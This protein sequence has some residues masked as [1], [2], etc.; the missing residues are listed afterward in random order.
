MKRTTLLIATLI[1]T[2]LAFANNYDFVFRH[3]S[4]YDGLWSNAVRAVIQD[5]KGYIWIGADAG[6]NRFDGI[7]MR[8]F[9]FSRNSFSQS[10][11]ALLEMGDTIFIGTFNGA[12]VLKMSTEEMKPFNIKAD[13]GSVINTQIMSISSDKDG[14]VWFATMGQGVY[15][16][17]TSN[18]TLKR[19]SSWNEGRIGQVY[20]DSKNQVW[21]VTAW[22][23]NGLWL[24]N[25]S[26]K[27]FEPFLID[28][29]KT[30]NGMAMTET[31]DGQLWLGTWTDG[32]ICFDREGRGLSR[33]LQAGDANHAIHIHSMTEYKPGVLL[34][35]CDNGLILSDTNTNISYTYVKDELNPTSISGAFV[36]PVFVDNEGGIWVGTFYSGLNYVSPSAGRF[37]SYKHSRLKNSV[38]GNVIGRFCEDNQHNIWIAS[39]DGGLNKYNPSTGLFEHFSIGSGNFDD[40]NIHALCI[41]GNNLWIGTYTGGVYVL[42]IN[43]GKQRNYLTVKGN[44]N[45]LYDNS[46]YAIFKDSH[47]NIWVT[48]VDGI[49]LYQPKTDD[50]KRIKRIGEIIV[51]IDEDKDGNLWFSTQGKGI[52]RFDTK[53]GGVWKNYSSPE[54]PDNIVNCIHIDKDNNIWAATNNGL[55]KYN[56]TKDTFE[57]IDIGEQTCVEGI[58]E[59]EGVLWITTYKGLIKYVEGEQPTIF[60]TNDGLN[61]NQ[62]LS[63]AA[64]MAS[65]GQVYIG[66]VNGFNTFYPYQI[67]KNPVLP[68]TVITGLE[69]MN[70]PI[71]IG[72]E[73]L[74]KSLDAVDIVNLSYRDKM[75]SISFASLSYCV[76][77]KNNY[78]YQL[79]GFDKTWNYIENQTRVTYTNLSPGKYKFRVKGTN[80]DG[81][82]SKE[83]TVLRIVIHPP[84]YWSM[85]AKILYTLLLFALFFFVVYKSVSRERKRQELKIKKL[86]EEKEKEVRNTKIQFFTMV[87]H[88]IRTPVSL[89]IGPLENLMKTKAALS[90]SER[91]NLNIIDRNAHRLLDLVNQL[92]DFRK[93]EK[94]TFVMN[95]KVQNVSA[96][97]HAV[98]ERFEPTFAQNGV[99]FVTDYPDNHF[100]AIIDCEA[101]TKVISNLLTNARKYTKDYVRLSCIVSPDDNHFIIE[102]RDNGVGINKSDRDRI[103][104]AFYQAADNKPGTGIGLS[105][106]KNIVDKHNGTVEVKSEPGHGSTFIVTLPVRQEMSIEGRGEKVEG[107]GEKVE[108]RDYQIASNQGSDYSLPSTL[109]P[110][111]SQKSLTPQSSILLVDDNDDMLQYLES[112]ISQNYN[113]ITAHDGI[114]ALDKLQNNDVSLIICDWMMPRMDGTEF[115]R[116][117]RANSETSH[118]PFIMLTAK[119]D[120]DSKAE[121][122]NVGVDAYIEKPFSMKYLEACYRNIISLRQMLRQKYSSTP[123]EPITEIAQSSVDKELLLKMQEIIESNFSNPD[124]SVNFLAEKLCLSRSSLFSKIKTLADMTP[125]EMIQTIRLKK[126]AQLLREGN[127]KVNEVCYSVGFSNPS[128]FSKCFQKQFG[129]KPTEL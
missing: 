108:G 90:Q 63:N 23:N 126:A 58:V 26:K 88:E 104:E 60:N 78:A 28:K 59:D 42:D 79:E 39:D 115:C 40:N 6:L 34:L 72:D 105:I 9:N 117:V 30:P 12:Y 121:G 32:L 25:R 69:V 4:A 13:D 76:P 61:S 103:F 80:N 101:V 98:S 113:V 27:S 31:S 95:F 48:T 109:L 96:L 15:R 21:A 46:S 20:V 71:H 2:W 127:L 66:T 3:Y 106:V 47:A 16:Y 120:I 62:F 75:F 53:L 81:S 68:R 19:Y 50:F 84:F 37:K 119:T 92:L 57:L 83:E 102:V 114:E 29:Q 99:K 93:V 125:N 56:H 87:A 24:F 17:Q 82:W 67:K 128:Y 55:V 89:I 8:Q 36:Y 5:K 41:D 43:T 118:I 65:D 38:H 124:L 111:P 35:G 1:Y 107:R 54:V 73:R 45:T 100:T 97:I 11:T 122:M 14:G 85:P 10:A 51:D 123:L 64:F 22:Q 112:N 129:I 86:N 77:Q 116:N 49:T 110:L 91:N 18:N 74:A 94:H 7:S 44:N 33:C 52:Y 70:K